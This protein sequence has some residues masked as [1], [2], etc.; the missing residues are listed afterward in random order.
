MTTID[1]IHE[2]IKQIMEISS[3]NNNYQYDPFKE[4]KCYDGTSINNR[5]CHIT[6]E[7]IIVK[8]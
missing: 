1:Y 3:A 2:Q 5:K 6:N 4:N 8:T 7:I